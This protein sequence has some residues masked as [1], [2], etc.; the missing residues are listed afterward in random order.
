M[1][2]VPNVKSE[3]WIELL[4]CIIW[5]FKLRKKWL[6][7]YMKNEKRINF[8]WI[9]EIFSHLYSI[10]NKHTDYFQTLDN[11]EIKPVYPKENQHWIFTGRTDTKTKAAILWL[12]DMKSWL[13]IE[14]KTMVLG[15]IE[16]KRRRGWQRMRWL[17]G[18]TD[19]MDMCLSKLQEMLKDRE[20]WCA[21]IHGVAKSWTWLTEQQIFLRISVLKKFFSK[22]IF[23]SFEESF[24][25][26]HYRVL[27]YL[28]VPYVIYEYI[29]V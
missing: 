9:L 1:T 25:I 6:L 26:F 15:K 13:F 27:I 24:H 8:I 17:D 10:N 23:L 12:H 29:H 28:Q 7:Q 14:E 16:V 3:N 5:K 4:F 22:I 21:A 20:A 19:S 2:N 18:I 11:K